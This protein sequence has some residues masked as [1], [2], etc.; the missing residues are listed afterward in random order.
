MGAVSG[1][2]KVRLDK[3]PLG[4][5]RYTAVVFLDPKA[6]SV[7]GVRWCLPTASSMSS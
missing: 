1:D 5:N 6:D 2:D 7:R 4:R 3:L